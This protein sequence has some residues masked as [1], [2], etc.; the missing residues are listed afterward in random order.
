[1]TVQSI[2]STSKDRVSSE[3]NSLRFEGILESEAAICQNNQI[4]RNVK[5]K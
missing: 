2:I 4:R 1:M 5:F 3:G